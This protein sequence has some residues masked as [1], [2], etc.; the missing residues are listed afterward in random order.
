MFGFIIIRHVNSRLTDLYWKECYRCIRKWHNE[1]IL[2]IDDSSTSDLTED[3]M[4]TNCTII[5]DKKYPGR[6]E[7]LPYYYFHLLHPFEQAIIIHDSVFIQEKMTVIDEPVQFLWHFSKMYDYDIVDY[8]HQLIQGNYYD[9]LKRI[10]DGHYTGCFGIMS[11]MKWSFLDQ[12]QKTHSLFSLLDK[13]LSR[14]NRCALERA[15]ALMIYHMYPNVTSIYGDIH[16]Y[17][18]WGYTFHQY[19]QEKQSHAIV[20]VWSGR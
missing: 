7:L 2:I 18:Q 1:P 19:I 8:I 16:A 14:I 6:A 15:L 17:I 5:Y 13:V 10:Y 20:K 12:L 11:M 9:A 4:L 3:I